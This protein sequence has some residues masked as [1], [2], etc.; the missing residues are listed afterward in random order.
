[1]LNDKKLSQVKEK[2]RRILFELGIVSINTNMAQI[3][4]ETTFRELIDSKYNIKMV[5]NKLR[6]EFVREELMRA[7][8][9]QRVALTHNLI[10]ASNSTS[11]HVRYKQE[12]KLDLML[13]KPKRPQTD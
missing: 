8:L 7:N 3:K 2:T 9:E 4:N 5:S 1:M 13:K 6:D 10:E 11:K 12:I